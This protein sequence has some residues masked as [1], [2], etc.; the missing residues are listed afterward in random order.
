M[1]TSMTGFGTAHGMVGAF[2]VTVDVRA[3]NH[4]FFTPTIKLP[5]AMAAWEGDVRELLR[6]YV[7]RGH[8]TLSAWTDRQ[9]DDA[10]S[11]IDVERFG[12]YVTQLRE[13]RDRFALSGDVDLATVLKL[14][15]VIATPQGEAATG[16]AAELLAIVDTAM[17]AL[18]AMRRV[19]GE[20]TATYLLERLAVIEGALSRIAYRAP[21]RMEE[22]RRR[23][24]ESI[25][26]LAGGVA[27]DQQRL[28]QEIAILADRLDVAEELSRFQAHITA[29]QTAVT[30]TGGATGGDAVGK[31]LGFLLQEMLREA[32]TT[33]SK[34]NDAPMLAD[35][36]VIKE[37][38]ERLREQVENVE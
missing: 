16:T 6:K 1:I 32:N 14:P 17:R 35:V 37:E 23:M 24:R 38:L 7:T 22:Q 31:R 10:V 12:A 28:A 34:A 13:L 29:F 20:R 18:T 19:E 9:G 5:S 11:A 36:V 3:V 26:E 33:G 25:E 30:A 2:A 21:T 15:N 4:R 27:V 8:V